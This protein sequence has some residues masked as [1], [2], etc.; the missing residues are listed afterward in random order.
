[1]KSVFI[2]YVSENHDPVQHLAHALKKHQIEV[3]INQ[4]FRS[5]GDEWEK[6]I[7]HK[8]AQSDF[9]IACFSI[10]YYNRTHTLMNAEL[11]E[12]IDKIR[13]HPTD[14]PWFIPVL[15]SDCEVPTHDIGRGETLRSLQS[16][17]LYE[18][19]HAGIQNILSVI[20]S[21]HVHKKK[22]TKSLNIYEPDS[23][24]KL[25]SQDNEISPTNVVS[26]Q[27]V[28]KNKIELMCYIEPWAEQYIIRPNHS[29]T[30]VTEGPI[31]HRLEIAIGSEGF[32]VYGW[33][34][35]SVSIQEG[36]L[37]NSQAVKKHLE[38]AS[39][40]KSRHQATHCDKDSTIKIRFLNMRDHT[41]T[42][43]LEPWSE[44]CALAS[45]EAVDLV[46]QGPP[47]HSLEIVWTDDQFTLYGWPG[48][49]AHMQPVPHRSAQSQPKDQP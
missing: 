45:T 38:H 13:Q 43:V 25:G 31:G 41:L 29:F 42:C 19:W 15:L 34:G 47:D 24:N 39:N 26:T 10:E 14:H 27:F 3:W 20:K 28:N 8:I 16:I 49:V 4:A 48:S 35:S 36:P 18:N 30:V 40:D 33:P 6:I 1:M 37:L 17:Q 46:I 9:F 32:T 12:A 22:S 23:L 44:F 21:R 7:R 11:T 2:S 5:S